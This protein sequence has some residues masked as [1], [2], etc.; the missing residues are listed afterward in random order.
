MVI[1]KGGCIGDVCVKCGGGFI[2]W[3]WDVDVGK[4]G[5]LNKA[6]PHIKC[7]TLCMDRR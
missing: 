2:K 1:W 3:V 7:H 4:A 5:D 6:A